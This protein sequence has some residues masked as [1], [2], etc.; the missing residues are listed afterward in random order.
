MKNLKTKKY[1]V[2]ILGWWYGKNY[3]SILTYYGL[4]KAINALGLNVLMVHE[5]LGY[6]GFRVKWPDNILSI[7]F[8]NRMGYSYTEQKH[9]SNLSELN[10]DVE[11]FVVGSDQLWN[12]L[13][14][15]VNDDLFLDF[16]SPQ[17]RRIAYA[18][19]FGNRGIAKFKPE[20]IEK[21]S[22][23]LQKFSGI[24]VRENY[25]ISTARDVFGVEA[26]QV[27]DPVFLIQKNHY[28]ALADTATIQL[29]S[30]YLSVFFL[31]PTPEKVTVALNIAKKLNLSRIVVIPNPDNGRKLVSELFTD[32]IFYIMPEDSPENFLYTYSKASYVLTD[33]FHGSAFAVIFGKPFS[34]IYNKNRGADRFKSLMSSL[35]LGESRRVFETATFEDIYQNK[36][37]SLSFDLSNVERIIEAE[38]MASISWL[39]DALMPKVDGIGLLKTIKSAF[40][41]KNKVAESTE[42][43]QVDHLSFNSSSKAWKKT[44]E[45]NITELRVEEG[46]AVRGNLTWCDLPFELVK[47]EAYRIK[48]RWKLR[49]S[50][51]TVNLHIRNP[52]TKK[53]NVIASLKNISR[54]DG[55][56]S[57]T[58]DFIVKEDGY[59]QF[60]LGAIH[61]QGP[62][63]GL[64]IESIEIREILPSAINTGPL[65]QDHTGKNVSLN[66]NSDNN[67]WSVENS[68][69][70]TTLTVINGSGE[71]GNLVWSKLPHKLQKNKAYR[72]K[73]DWVIGTDATAVT[74]N[75]QNG[76]DKKFLPIGN[77]ALGEKRRVRRTDTL[78]FS[79]PVE[80]MDRIM[81][82]SSQ[83]IGKNPN[84]L[85][86]K[87][88]IE[89]KGSQDP[90]IDLAVPTSTRTISG[91]ISQIKS[92]KLVLKW[93]E[94]I[95]RA[96]NSID[97]NIA[98]EMKSLTW[99]KVGGPADIMAFPTSLKQ[100]ETLINIAIENDI[101][102]TILGLC[103]NVL[104]RD[105]G[106]RGLVISTTKLNHMTLDN[107][108]FT[109]G[110][111]AGLTEAAFH[112]LEYGK[113]GLDWAAGI[114]G[115]L[116]GAVYMN[117][118]T[119]IS[120]IRRCIESVTFIDERGTIRSLHVSEISW[121]KRYSTF[122][123]RKQWIILEATFRVVEG[124]A[125][126]LRK[127]MQA[128][129]KKREN[130]FPL[131][132][133]NHGSTFKWWRA[134]RLI[135]QCGLVGYKIGG[136][137]ISTK[138]PGFFVNV[139]NAS[140][141]DYEALINYTVSK[142]YEKSS[143]LMEPEVEIIGER[144]HRYE[145]YTI[146]KKT[147]D[148]V[149]LDQ[150]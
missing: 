144:L 134:P 107:D 121:G 83:F 11:T 123:S 17:N 60:M 120:D 22:Q 12:P 59:T 55:I 129:I 112:L 13:I 67:S 114:P 52:D 14:G 85:I 142:V 34:S 118:G 42:A 5:P 33:S 82:G 117:A 116:G 9:F 90:V 65:I 80:G 108:R 76:K 111:G 104:V 132:L 38:R 66:F 70:N 98:K 140:A 127:Q 84:A 49:T 47:D 6:N 21:H 145:S 41:S 8:A 78:D 56:R 100:L 27:V 122:Q 16:V 23:N 97:L 149:R 141:S 86:Y 137:Q 102:T 29:E 64:S 125:K 20:F 101:P 115:T 35:G 92:D 138:Q 75:V 50:S 93:K 7:K 130:H 46:A 2:G 73:I 139:G 1:D 25:A 124:N 68:S 69:E 133:P 37:I 148:D 40:S 109:V 62:D 57:D 143:F 88:T 128:T 53:F 150:R 36:N 71:R 61:F 95:E 105:G 119:N 39:K 106:L 58:I 74:L 113:S 96:D 89:D 94:I 110:A 81:I 146:E 31:D 136:A 44:T 18:T 43:N 79:V 91:I 24:S 131:D 48:V 147:D 126:E 26:K 30:G 10:N 54:N 135:S 15:R 63:A 32:P 19:S 3:G 51:N 87:I 72:V 77:V 28:Q 103:T 45:N 4:N 99:N